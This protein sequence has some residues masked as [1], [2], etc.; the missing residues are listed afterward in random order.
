MFKRFLTGWLVRWRVN[1]RAATKISWA[2]PQNQSHFLHLF[3][4][5]ANENL[6]PSHKCQLRISSSE[7]ALKRYYIRYILQS[8]SRF[9]LSLF[10]SQIFHSNKKIP[11]IRDNHFLR[12]LRN[13]EN[14]NNKSKIIYLRPNIFT[15]S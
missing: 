2:L 12:K 13:E 11:C 5:V 10:E 14:E 15:R 9:P 1:K 8:H 4:N 7:T 6:K 3:L